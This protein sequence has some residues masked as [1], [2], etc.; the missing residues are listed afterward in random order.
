MTLQMKP[1]DC[2]MMLLLLLLLMLHWQLTVEW[3][4]VLSCQAG[5]AARQQLVQA[6]GRGAAA[7]THVVDQHTPLRATNAATCSSNSPTQS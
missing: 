2:L 3:Q 7:A 5:L 4:G 6:H 1:I